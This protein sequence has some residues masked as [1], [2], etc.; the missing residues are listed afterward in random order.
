MD[1]PTIAATWGAQMPAASTTSSV[2]IG[3]RSVITRRTARRGVELDPGHPRARP[4]PD[5]ERTGRVGHGMGRAVRV[6]VAVLGEVDRAVEVVRA[7]RRH[8]ADGLV[9]RDHLDVQPDPAGAAGGPLELAQLIRARGEPQ[10]AR[11]LE[12]AQPL[13]QLDAVAAEGASSS[14]TG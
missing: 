7:D 2:S 11:P 14:P 9:G 6:E 1:A 5:A 13:V 12:D 8:A 10:A 4:D 3:P